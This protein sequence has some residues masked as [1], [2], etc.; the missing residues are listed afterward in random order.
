MYSRMALSPAASEIDKWSAAILVPSGIRSETTSN[1]SP[2]NAS[3]ASSTVAKLSSTY[4][5]HAATERAG[6]SVVRAGYS[7]SAS[8]SRLAARPFSFMPSVVQM[9]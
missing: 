5:V 8:H 2:E 6:L 7:D 3:T 1:R 4:C 9:S